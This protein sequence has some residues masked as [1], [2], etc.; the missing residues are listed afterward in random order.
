MIFFSFSASNTTSVSPSAT[1]SKPPIFP[2]SP[3]VLTEASLKEDMPPFM[4][5]FVM[6]RQNNSNEN[7]PVPTKRKTSTANTSNPALNRP[8]SAFIPRPNARSTSSD[9]RQA[10]QQRRRSDFVSRYE[11]LLGRAQA[12]AK[13]V[14]ELD[15]LRLQRNTAQ[16]TP[17]MNDPQASEEAV[18]APEDEDEEETSVDFNEEGKNQLFFT[19]FKFPPNSQ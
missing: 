16:A 18:E 9:S 6:R 10:D 14:D 15:L 13:A 7:T 5:E 19:K 11:S 2:T 8:H 17:S 4:K 1:A 3:K 12:A